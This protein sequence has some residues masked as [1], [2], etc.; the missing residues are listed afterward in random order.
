MFLFKDLACSRFIF[1]S[2]FNK[3]STRWLFLVS[4]F[5]IK[6][7]G[8]STKFMNF[9]STVGIENHYNYPDLKK[10]YFWEKDKKIFLSS[11]KNKTIFVDIPNYKSEYIRH[12]LPKSEKFDTRG[13]QYTFATKI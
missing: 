10:R 9:N 13:F 7:Q 2:G 4:I 1:H 6:F 5:V 8:I 11:Y 12:I 3:L